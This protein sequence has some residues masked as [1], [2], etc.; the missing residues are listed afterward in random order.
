MSGNPPTHRG[1]GIEPLGTPISVW[2]QL[3]GRAPPTLSGPRF[4][5]RSWTGATKA[6]RGL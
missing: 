2:G 1:G 5:A 3:G 6:W 4:A